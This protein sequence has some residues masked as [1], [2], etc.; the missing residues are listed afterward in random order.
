MEIITPQSKICVF[1]DRKFPNLTIYKGGTYYRIE[2][3]SKIWNSIEIEFDHNHSY[4]LSTDH[5]SINFDS[6]EELENR[7]DE[8]INYT[9]N[10]AHYTTKKEFEEFINRIATVRYFDDKRDEWVID[11]GK[12]FRYDIQADMILKFYNS[13]KGSIFFN[14]IKTFARY[15][16]YVK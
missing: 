2:D 6:F 12:V 8:L 13:H 15:Y 3:R 16:E 1:L 5:F 10:S 9:D 4:F 11:D 14:D 7:F